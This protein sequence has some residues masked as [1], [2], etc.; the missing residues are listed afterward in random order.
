MEIDPFEGRRRDCSRFPQ[1]LMKAILGEAMAVAEFS[2]VLKA[3][4]LMDDQ[5][6][7]PWYAIQ[8]HGWLLKYERH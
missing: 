7:L 4:P 1:Y 8:V 6:S 3:L 5:G 2:C